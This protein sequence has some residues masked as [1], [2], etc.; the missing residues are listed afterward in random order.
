MNSANIIQA[1]R[2]PLLLITLGALIVLD[3]HTRFKFNQ[4]WPVLIILFGVLKLMERM[5]VGAQPPYPPGSPPG[6]SPGGVPPPGY[7]E[8]PHNT[9]GPQS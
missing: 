4:T 5:V 7:H 9:G 3:Y 8:P 2:G 6:V 1:A